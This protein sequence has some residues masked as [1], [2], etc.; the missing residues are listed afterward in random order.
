MYFILAI[1]TFFLEGVRGVT[2]LPKGSKAQ[3]TLEP[4]LSADEIS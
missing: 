1:N 3:K 2:R 4:L